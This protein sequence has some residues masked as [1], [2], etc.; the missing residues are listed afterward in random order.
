MDGNLQVFLYLLQLFALIICI[1]GLNSNVF[2]FIANTIVFWWTVFDATMICI[3]IEI[4][5][6]GNKE[7]LWSSE[8]TSSG[9]II[10]SNQITTEI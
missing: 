4:I 2:K 9:S 3:L 5:S 8:Y 1:L 10:F 7:R 6:Q